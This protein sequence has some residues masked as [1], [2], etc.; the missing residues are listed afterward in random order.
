MAEINSNSVRAFL[1]GVLTVNSIDHLAT[2][3]VGKEFLTPLAGKN[4]GPLVNALWGGANLMGGLALAR[5]AASPGPRWGP[6]AHAF[7][8]GAAAFATWMFLSEV[9]LEVNTSG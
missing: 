1:S 6:E 5:S 2:A 3:A 7:G 4:S 9:L 8:A